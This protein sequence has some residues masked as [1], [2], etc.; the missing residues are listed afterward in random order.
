MDITE[1]NVTEMIFKEE[2]IDDL[3]SSFT[4]EGY[5]VQIQSEDLKQED[6]IK[7]EDDPLS[8]VQQ[9]SLVCFKSPCLVNV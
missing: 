6:D 7:Q 9:T 5:R 1:S 2:V 4:M 3:D 8:E